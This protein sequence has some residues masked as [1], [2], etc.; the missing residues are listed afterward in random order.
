MIGL[1]RCGDRKSGKQDNNS[2]D[3][4]FHKIPLVELKFNI[5][6]Q[7]RQVKFIQREVILKIIKYINYIC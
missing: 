5:T 4:L 6:L 1:S 2:N 7:I 3:R